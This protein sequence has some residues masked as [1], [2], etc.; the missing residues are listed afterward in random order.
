ML[1]TDS[2]ESHYL[3]PLLFKMSESESCA[4]WRGII[5]LWTEEVGHKREDKAFSNCRIEYLGNGFLGL[6]LP[7]QYRPVLNDERA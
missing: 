7:E 5:E 3:S 6:P 2:L 4:S 1:I